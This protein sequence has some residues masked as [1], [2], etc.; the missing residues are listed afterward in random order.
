MQTY[1]Y[2]NNNPYKGTGFSKAEKE[3][4]RLRKIQKLLQ[5][6]DIPKELERI[7]QKKS[8]LSST[9]RKTVVLYGNKYLKALQTKTNCSVNCKNKNCT[10]NKKG[11]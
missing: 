7:K 1:Y 5:F 6:I 9:Q 4:Q 3:N 8:K 2:H 10:C 11:A